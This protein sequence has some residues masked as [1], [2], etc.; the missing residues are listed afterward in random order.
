MATAA[1]GAA[2]SSRNP[3]LFCADDRLEVVVEVVLVVEGPDATRV[4]EPAEPVPVEPEV[5]EDGGLVTLKTRVRVKGAAYVYSMLQFEMVPE[6]L[7]Q[8][9]Y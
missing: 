2:Y 5:L 3:T 1:T 8:V 9:Q 4:L 7:V 6:L